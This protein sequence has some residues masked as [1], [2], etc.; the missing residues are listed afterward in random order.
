LPL[1]GTGLAKLPTLKPWVKAIF[2]LYLILTIPALGTLFVLMLVQLP[3]F[4]AMTWS[5]FV[6]Q[7]GIVANPPP[8]GALVTRAAALV[9]MALLVLPLVG[10]LYL[11]Q[12]V[13]RRLAGGLWAWSK[14]T[15]ARRFAGVLAGAASLALIA[16]LWAPQAQAVSSLFSFSLAA[17][18]IDGIPCAAEMLTYHVHAHLTILDH[19]KP[20]PVPAGLGIDAAH[21]CLYWLHTHDATG[22]IHVEAPHPT[23]LTL[24][25]FFDIWGKPLSA[26]QVG[27]VKV[28]SGRQMRVYVDLQPYAGDPRRIQLRAHTTITIEIGAPFSPPQRYSFNGL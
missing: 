19:G 16:F 7:M 12:I 22:V 2:A 11:L 18:P 9:Q 26:K 17:P 14:P 6:V 5:S 3:T 27:D 28:G 25:Q 4:V 20:V 21:T 23:Q 13:L 15:R 10:I 24:G 8:D 1:P